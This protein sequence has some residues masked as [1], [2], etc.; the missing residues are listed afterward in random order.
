L[1]IEVEEKKKK[2]TVGDPLK[3]AAPPK[4]HGEKTAGIHMSQSA[5][6]I[7]NSKTLHSREERKRQQ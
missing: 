1:H 5:R 3:K 4:P 2:R 6:G 7:K